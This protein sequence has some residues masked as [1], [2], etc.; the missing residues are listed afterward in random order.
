MS[1]FILSNRQ[2]QKDRFRNDGKEQARPTFRIAKAE[3]AEESV[4]Y[5]ILP[6]SFEQHYDRLAQDLR[7][8]SQGSSPR[9]SPRKGTAQMFGQLYQEMRD[10][11]GSQGDLLFFIHGFANSFEDNL[12]HIR[13]LHRLYV[14]PSNS[15]VSH[16][17]YLSWPSQSSKI[18]T[19]SDDQ[20]DA[21]VTGQVLSRIY[22]KLLEFFQQ[23]FQVEDQA[24]CGHQVHMAA[25]SM[26]NQ[27]LMHLL[28]SVPQRQLRP[29]I[30]EVLLLHSDVPDTVYEPGEPFQKLHRLASR[31]HIYTHQ[32]DDA[33]ALSHFTKNGNKRLGKRGPSRMK[34]LPEDTFRV[35]V[36]RLRADESLRERLFDHWGY[37]ESPGQI[38]DIK[39]VF[40]G[41]EENQ[42]EGRVRDEDEKQ[43]YR[44]LP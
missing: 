5:E 33:L 43:L 24:H 29:V 17:V 40:R 23:L 28:E 39:A 21:Q 35:E 9:T 3:I 31:T 36:S 12:Q 20:R 32:S 42:I 27:V 22:S 8:E 6:D 37:L 10:Y 26:G 7:K 4:S 16:L 25:H 41:E 15:P 13:K 2:V 11:Q 34:D 44:L 38:E 1:I 14:E 18:L 30:G 19:Y